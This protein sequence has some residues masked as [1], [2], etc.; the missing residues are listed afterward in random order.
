MTQASAI[1]VG[2][3]SHE[4]TRPRRHR[5]RYRVFMLL[6]DLDELQALDQRLKRFSLG[7][8]NLLSFHE[9]D[10]GVAEGQSLKQSILAKLAA[11]GIELP[12]ARISL[13][14]MPRVLGHGFNP[15]SVYFCH[16]GDG[17]LAA[18]VHAVRNTFG[19]SHDYV[20]PVRGGRGGWVRQASDK[21]FHVSP[22]LPMDLRYVFEIAPPGEAVHVGIDVFYEEGLKLAAS[23]DGRR[24][25]LTDKALGRALMGHP[26]Q[27]VGVLVGIHWEALKMALK[28]FGLFGSPSP[29]GV[30][31]LPQE[32][33]G[34]G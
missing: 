10:H 28:G 5:L 14:C 6:L 21:I 3:V 18:I 4:R 20:L 8:F 22:F 26:L 25:E 12:H 16:D 32:K 29:T 11:Q 7:R 23:F 34:A 17:R 19:Q 1:Y 13:L 24:V 27:V 30:L 2:E 9:R 33:G 31:P 15:L